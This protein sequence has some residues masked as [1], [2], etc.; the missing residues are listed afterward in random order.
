MAS[1]ND[2]DA[3]V[4]RRVCILVIDAIDGKVVLGQD[5]NEEWSLP[6]AAIQADEATPEVAGRRLAQELQLP[7][8]AREL[9]RQADWTDVSD[10]LH[11]DLS[12][13]VVVFTVLSQ[14]PA[15]GELAP[16]GGFTAL[17]F[18]R[19][20]SLPDELT[21]TSRRLV[22]EWFAG[23]QQTASGYRGMRRRGTAAAT[24]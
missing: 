3:D 4:T 24:R 2:P 22:T 18:H 7:A 12:Q 5:A 19:P 20:D 1:E 17:A 21:T 10:P 8:G 14:E 13:T 16:A 15:A 6:T 11:T 9:Q 23:L